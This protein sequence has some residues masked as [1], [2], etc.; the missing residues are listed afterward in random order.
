MRTSTCTY[1]VILFLSVSHSTAKE[2]TWDF[3]IVLLESRIET[4]LVIYGLIY[5]ILTVAG[6]LRPEVSKPNLE[7]QILQIFAFPLKLEGW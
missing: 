4:D 1:S 7:I 3:N 2:C 5:L 6:I